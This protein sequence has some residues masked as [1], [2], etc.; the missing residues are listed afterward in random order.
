MIISNHGYVVPMPCKIIHFLMPSPQALRAVFPTCAA[1]VSGENRE[2]WTI[3]PA[4]FSKAP[5]PAHAA[6]GLQMAYGMGGWLALVLHAL[7]VEIY[8]GPSFSA[9]HPFPTPSF[10]FSSNTDVLLGLFPS[11][12]AYFICCDFSRHYY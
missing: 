7:G 5:S 8:V 1:Y 12:T 4:Q 11:T 3:V 6:A 10:H 2:L 9:P